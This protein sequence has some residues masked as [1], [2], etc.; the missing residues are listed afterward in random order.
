[1]LLD[2]IGMDTEMMTPISRLI[3][4]G[5]SPPNARR[6]SERETARL[7]SGPGTGLMPPMRP[8]ASNSDGLTPAGMN[9]GAGAGIGM[10]SGME[11]GDFEQRGDEV[12]NEILRDVERGRGGGSVVGDYEQHGD[13]GMTHSSTQHLQYSQHQH[14]HQNQQYHP[15]TVPQPPLPSAVHFQDPISYEYREQYEDSADFLRQPHQSVD[16]IAKKQEPSG[17][18]TAGGDIMNGDF[19]QMVFREL[20][21]PLMVAILILLMGISQ[22]DDMLGKFIPTLLVDGRLGYGGLIAKAVVG[23]LIYYAVQRIFL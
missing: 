22:A 18:A 12:V 3:P 15:S 16:V 11:R 17:D 20:R 9:T 23:G 5:S 19:L 1:M 10:G 7:V 21:L 13:D 2:S 4:T 8:I 6:P 14:Q